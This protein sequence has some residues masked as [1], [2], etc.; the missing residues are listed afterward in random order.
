MITK[1]Y[2]GFVPRTEEQD[3][4]W[5]SRLDYCNTNGQ[6]T[7]E[8]PWLTHTSNLLTIRNLDMRRFEGVAHL[9]QHLG[10]P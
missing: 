8:A 10:E 1:A 6:R 7:K 3:R 5:E 9:M 2:N 4:A